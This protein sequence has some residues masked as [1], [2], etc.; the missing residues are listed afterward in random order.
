MTSH[1]LILQRCL[2]FILAVVAFSACQKPAKQGPQRDAT[3][4]SALAAGIEAQSKAFSQHAK[5][6]QALDEAPASM[7]QSIAETQQLLETLMQQIKT[8]DALF[9]AHEIACKRYDV[10]QQN[11]TQ[12]ENTIYRPFFQIHI[13]ALQNM[14]Q[15]RNH[16]GQYKENQAMAAFISELEA[17]MHQLAD[18]LREQIVVCER[19][20][21]PATCLPLRQY[22]D[23]SLAFLPPRVVD[24]SIP[25]VEK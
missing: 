20:F 10:Q 24:A 3:A 23:R 18:A 13:L 9:N 5:A 4:C 6:F 22:I 14:L 2:L 8:V 17:Q 1:V 19:D 12:V 11:Y 7:Q 21:D 15:I 16:L 25:R